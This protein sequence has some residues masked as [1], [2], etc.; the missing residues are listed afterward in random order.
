MTFTIKRESL[1]SQSSRREEESLEISARLV[2]PLERSLWMA[3][4]L[5]MQARP[6]VALAPLEKE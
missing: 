1:I 6:R 4:V 5:S 3:I 2:L